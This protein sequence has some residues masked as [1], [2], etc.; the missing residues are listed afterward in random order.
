MSVIDFW[1]YNVHS[2]IPSAHDVTVTT[3]HLRQTADNNVR[4]RKYIDVDEVT[5]TLIDYDAK[6][7]LVC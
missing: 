6:V 3:K 5:N 1:L 7:V 4:I 2:D